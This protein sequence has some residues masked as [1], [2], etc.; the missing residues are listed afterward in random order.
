MRKRKPVSQRSMKLYVL[1][2]ELVAIVHDM[3][4]RNPMKIN[5]F[6]ITSLVCFVLG[7]CMSQRTGKRDEAAQ[8]HAELTWKEEY[9]ACGYGDVRTYA[10]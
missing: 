5:W 9:D 4:G 10:R 8:A 3:T 2:G 1:T 7:S 6:Y